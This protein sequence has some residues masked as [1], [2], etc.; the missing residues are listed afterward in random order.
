[1][2]SGPATASPTLIPLNAQS[3]LYSPNH[4]LNLISAQAGQNPL[5]PPLNHSSEN[6][7]DKGED[8]EAVYV[9]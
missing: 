8:K 7:E 3:Q 5:Q 9:E 1:M 6:E 2:C 4:S